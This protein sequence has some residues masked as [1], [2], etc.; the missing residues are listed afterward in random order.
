MIRSSAAGSED[1][2]L[3]DPCETASSESADRRCR[4]LPDSI[5][6]TLR[7]WH[8]LEGMDCIMYLSHQEGNVTMDKE[9]SGLQ[10]TN[11]AR[12]TIRELTSVNATVDHEEFS[13]RGSRVGKVFVIRNVT[14][15]G[16]VC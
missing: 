16:K 4:R 13:A 11:A 3:F 2:Y 8:E 9:F 6:L 10:S 1:K 7:D 14:P 15:S 5:R 12:D